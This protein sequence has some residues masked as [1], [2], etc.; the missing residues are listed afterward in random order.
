M[1]EL[2]PRR[3]AEYD[4]PPDEPPPGTETGEYDEEDND[5]KFSDEGESEQSLSAAPAADKEEILQNLP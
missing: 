4:P 3:Y 1:N 5:D 2:F